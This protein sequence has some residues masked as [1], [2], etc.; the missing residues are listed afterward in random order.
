MSHLTHY[1]LQEHKISTRD[2]HLIQV[3]LAP[4]YTRDY[5]T[6]APSYVICIEPFDLKQEIS[7]NVFI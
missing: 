6:P 3:S 4:D 5:D 1:D 7:I 2:K